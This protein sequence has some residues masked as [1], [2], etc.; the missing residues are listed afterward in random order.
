MIEAPMSRVLV[1][2]GTGVL[3]RQ[4]RERLLSRGHTIRIAS[5]G[6]RREDAPA[7]VEWAQSKLATGEGLA[8]AVDGVDA[9][10]HAAS[11][12]FAPGKV[13]VG[14]THHLLRAAQRGGV[15]HL[16]YVSIVGI[17][18]F[19]LAYYRAK[20]AAEA[21]VEGGT[22]PFTILRATQFHELLDQR[23]L[24]FLFKL[25]FLALVPTDFRFQLVDSGEV[26]DRVTE[27]VEAGPTSGR[28]DDLG[29]PEVLTMG[30]IASSWKM[31]RGLS[32]RVVHLAMPGAAAAAFRRG[33]STCP[34]RRCGRITWER[35]LARR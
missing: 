7:D 27:L 9:V 5:R 34:E 31:A 18:D 8:E 33:Q 25:P 6:P 13:D 3:G 1:T 21:L 16:L 10:V 29:G 24:P 15:A 28:V 17:D 14:G 2:G 23:F 11:S 22:V 12:P 26:A 20:R 30:E 4:L 35:Y 32:K 19:P